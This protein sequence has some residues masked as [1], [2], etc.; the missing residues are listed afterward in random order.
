MVV[1]IKVFT[2]KYSI[3]GRSTSCRFQE[4]EDKCNEMQCICTHPH[5]CNVSSLFME[6]GE[7]SMKR[8]EGV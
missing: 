2:L 5:M 7:P 8:E 3:K 1:F 6:F 4:R